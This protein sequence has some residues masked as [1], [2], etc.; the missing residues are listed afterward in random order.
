[1]YYSEDEDDDIVEDEADGEDSDSSRVEA[2][3]PHRVHYTQCQLHCTLAAA[4]L[5]Q[6]RLSW[7]DKLY[8]YTF[9]EAEFQHLIQI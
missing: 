4:T 7:E 2:C 3:R 6:T 9:M 8:K 5:G 1:M